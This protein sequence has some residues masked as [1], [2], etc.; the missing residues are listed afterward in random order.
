MGLEKMDKK[1]DTLKQKKQEYLEG[2]KL[3]IPQEKNFSETTAR[4]AVKAFMWRIIAGTVTFFTSL[5]FS[6]S[7]KTA[8]T[9][10]GS[11]FFS[12]AITM[13][14]GERLMNKSKA[15]RKGGADNGKIVGE[16]AHL[17]TFR[18]CQHAD[19][20]P[21]HCEG[22]IHGLKD[23]RIRRYFQDRSYVRV[24]ESVGQGRVGQGIHRGILHLDKHAVALY[25]TTSSVLSV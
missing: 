8:L 11:D 4:S 17:E 23:R 15:G 6:G 25:V 21:T 7:I 16:S 2:L 10:V 3:G 18:Y 24:W 12:K 9:I 19:H 5:R 22:P 20:V 13:F 14:F 1:L